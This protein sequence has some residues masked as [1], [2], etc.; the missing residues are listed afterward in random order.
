VILGTPIPNLSYNSSQQNTQDEYS[1]WITSESS[2]ADVVFDTHQA[3]LFASGTAS[4]TSG[5]WFFAVS[6]G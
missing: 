6:S 4:G 3:T 5:I 2:G 1:S